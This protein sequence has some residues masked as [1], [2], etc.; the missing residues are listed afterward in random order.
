MYPTASIN[1]GKAD[2]AA[3]AASIIREITHSPAGVIERTAAEALLL[4][5]AHDAGVNLLEHVADKVMQ[6]RAIVGP[7]ARYTMTVVDSAF[8]IE[9]TVVAER[10]ARLLVR[11]ANHDLSLHAF[12]PPATEIL[13]APL[14][15]GV[16]VTGA[17]W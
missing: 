11:P 14:V 5:E 15:D 10:T 3:R 13:A 16:S 1:P 4:C 6:R 7:W 12:T 8:G 2:A 9:H 17:L